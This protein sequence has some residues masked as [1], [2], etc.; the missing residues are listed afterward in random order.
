MTLDKLTQFGHINYLNLK[1]NVNKIAHYM[2]HKFEYYNRGINSSINTH[3][4]Q[5]LVTKKIALIFLAISVIS[6][7]IVLGYCFTVT[8]M[9]TFVALGIIAIV[10]TGAIAGVLYLKNEF[11]HDPRF[12]FRVQNF[13]DQDVREN[14][15]TFGQLC[16]KYPLEMHREIYSS[17]DFDETVRDRLFNIHSFEEVINSFGKEC[18]HIINH[19]N[20]IFIK[21]H[22]KDSFVDYLL[23]HRV[24]R[25]EI[26]QD[27]LD[28]VDLFDVSINHCSYFVKEHNEKIK[29]ELPDIKSFKELIDKFGFDIPQLLN[30]ENYLSI[31]SLLKQSFLE[32]ICKKHIKHSELRNKFYLW[33]VLFD[34]SVQ[35]Y[36]GI[37]LKDLERVGIFSR[38][39]KRHGFVN[40]PM[41]LY[42]DIFSEHFRNVYYTY[43]LKEAS[44]KSISIL[45]GIFATV[46]RPYVK[47]YE[48]LRN[49]IGL[50]CLEFM[51][52]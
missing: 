38:F 30:E 29:K 19:R 26:R 39:I 1:D 10:T 9:P 11:W 8:V 33:M 49:Q 31:Q 25:R 42:G 20:K 15:L 50:K 43:L 41:W 40:H 36:E 47:N 51:V 45:E 46:G 7:E 24:S 18:I 32:Y 5:E 35:E 48:Y 34:P 28:W 2:G 21:N 3:I 17:R 52:R 23:T 22:F 27:Y 12:V 13:I 16:F 14:N 44:S 37:L 6:S 4:K